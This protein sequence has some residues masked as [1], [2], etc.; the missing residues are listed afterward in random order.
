MVLS[1]YGSEIQS[2]CTLKEIWLLQACKGLCNYC[3]VGVDVGDCIQSSEPCNPAARLNI[4]N[5]DKH[6]RIA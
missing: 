3:M 5:Y 6:V 4:D 1:D 2:L